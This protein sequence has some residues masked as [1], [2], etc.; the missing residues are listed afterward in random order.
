MGRLPV[1][2]V[3]L[4]TSDGHRLLLHT[5]DA[6]LFALLLLR[7]DATTDG[8]EAGGLLQLGD[9]AGGVAGLDHPDECGDVDAHGAAIH[10]FW[11]LALQAAAGLDHGHV[12]V[13]AESHFA[14][15]GRPLL[16][17]LAGHGSSGQL[18][19]LWLSLWSVRADGLGEIRHPRSP[20][21]CTPLHP[22][23]P[24]APN[25]RP[26]T[27]SPVRDTAA[28][29]TSTGRSRPCAHRTPARQR[30]RT[31]SRRRR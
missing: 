18:R 15:V 8:R 26:G 7:A 11:L 19:L 10:A 5:E 23:R 30:R 28:G 27:F 21:C 31:W 22:T 24:H 25:R 20:P 9:G 12:I 2:G 17:W 6:E 1:G 16:R 14:K 4:Q 13:V 3:T 29:A